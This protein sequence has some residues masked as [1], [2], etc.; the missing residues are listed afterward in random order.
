MFWIK[1]APEESLLKTYIDQIADNG[2]TLFL[3]YLFRNLLENCHINEEK[4]E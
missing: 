2:N 4:N 3:A 1:L